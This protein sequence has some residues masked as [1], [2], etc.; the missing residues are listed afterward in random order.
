MSFHF[1]YMGSEPIFSSCTCASTML[2]TTVLPLATS[3]HTI[4]DDSVTTSV[5]SFG[6]F[7]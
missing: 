3:F 5:E 4:V 1:Y 7:Q 6:D 2:L